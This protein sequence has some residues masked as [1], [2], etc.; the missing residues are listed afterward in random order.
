MIRNI[1]LDID[2]NNALSR[3]SDCTAFFLGGRLDRGHRI[4]V[5]INRKEK[6]WKKTESHSRKPTYRAE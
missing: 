1:D 2:L 6:V 3:A 4:E 5:T